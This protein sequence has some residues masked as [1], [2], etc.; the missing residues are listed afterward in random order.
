MAT[1]K[2]G[3][4]GADRFIGS[5]IAEIFDGMGNYDRVSYLGSLNPLSIDV[6]NGG[7]Q[8][9]AAG[10]T[11]LSIEHF[12]LGRG[13][14]YFM[15]DAKRQIIN[16][17]KGNDTIYGGGGTDILMGEAGNDTLVGGSGT[18]KMWGGSGSDTLIGGGGDDYLQGDNWGDVLEG[19][20]DNGTFTITPG[21]DQFYQY[22]STILIPL[23]Q[24]DDYGEWV[25][26]P[27]RHAVENGGALTSINRADGDAIFV[28]TNGWNDARD[29]NATVLGSGSRPTINLGPGGQIDPDSSVIF[30]A[31]SGTTTVI[32]NLSSEGGY[33]GPKSSGNNPNGVI[34]VTSYDSPH[35]AIGSLTAGDVLKGGSG[36]DTFIFNIGDGVDKILDFTKGQDLIDI[37]DTWFDGNAANGEFVAM[38]YGTGSVIFFSDT[39]ADHV[40]D[41]NAIWL[42][43]LGIANVDATIFV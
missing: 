12:E 21:T 2:K 38:T 22:S 6:A 32:F 26:V 17:Y 13:D 20:T 41:D 7:F 43:T 30:N 16:G 40:I 5:S 3:T 39:S 27:K 15:G 42:P 8:G 37:A 10:D 9:D 35:T 1:L 14:D 23:E 18:D 28:V 36:N 29:W 34:S 11:Y 4:N 24:I 33:P 19:G 25:V 31:G